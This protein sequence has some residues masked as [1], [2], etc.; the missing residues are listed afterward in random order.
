MLIGITEALFGVM[1]G[2]PPDAA[3]RV[4]VFGSLYL[5]NTHT[6]VEAQGQKDS[7]NGFNLQPGGGLGLFLTPNVGLQFTG[8]VPVTWND[9]DTGTGFRFGVSASFRLR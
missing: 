8:E 3:K 4:W 9:G 2:P 6:S 1:F 5:G 7:V